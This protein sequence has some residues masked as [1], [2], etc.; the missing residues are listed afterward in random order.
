MVRGAI[1]S[2]PSS[3]SWGTSTRSLASLSIAPHSEGGIDDTVAASGS[4]ASPPV[5]WSTP[6]NDRGSS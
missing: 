3:P 6:S 2:A 1:V 5:T 4:V